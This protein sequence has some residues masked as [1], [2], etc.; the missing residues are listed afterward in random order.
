MA[1]SLQTDVGQRK[2]SAPEEQRLQK[3]TT[4][5]IQFDYVLSGNIHPPIGYDWRKKFRQRVSMYIHTI[6]GTM[7]VLMTPSP[8]PFV[9]NMLERCTMIEI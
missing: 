8:P 3:M 9:F 6:D 5:K 2:S 1:L 4:L 7:T